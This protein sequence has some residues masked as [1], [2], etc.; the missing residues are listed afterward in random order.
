MK[1]KLK[2][3][4]L[5]RI[6]S[7]ENPGGDTVQI[8]QIV[9]YFKKNGYHV[10]VF[11]RL[12]P[13]LSGFDIAFIFNLTRYLD[14]FINAKACLEQNVKYILFPIYWNFDELN[15]PSYDF[16]SF[17]KNNILDIGF[18]KYLSIENYRK[19]FNFY[20]NDKLK[21]IIKNNKKLLMSEKKSIE[22]IMN[23]SMFICPNS[24]AEKE[25]LKENFNIESEEKFVV[26]Y[27]GIEKGLYKLTNLNWHERKGINCVGGIGPRK[28]QLNLLKAAKKQN[29]K[30]N[31][32]GKH[33]FK[34]KSYFSKVNR[35]N[36]WA[37]FYGRKSRKEVLKLLA[38]SKVHIQPSFIETPGLA[39][40]EAYVLGCKL[41]VSDVAPVKEYFEDRVIYVNPY[42]VKSI[43][44]ALV[45]LSISNIKIDL[46]EIRSFNKRFEWK[47]VLNKL[48]IIL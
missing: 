8:R 24:Y 35:F 22:Y 20:K 40:M 33:N 41:V 27:N 11:N 46:D 28:N 45:K 44:S 3:A 10:K 29:F 4:I 31:I 48:D 5:N 12:Y 16:K 30:I 32:I 21:P 37:T 36:N 42:S 6:D 2:V 38:N 18:L 43:E 47:N 25:H 9:K 23:N 34:D 15:I 1:F 19:I 17:L 13:K 14:A 7:K 39:S 26:I